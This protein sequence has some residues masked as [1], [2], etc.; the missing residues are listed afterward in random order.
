MLNA[1]NTYKQALFTKMPSLRDNLNACATLDKLIAAETR[2][3]VLVAESPL[4]CVVDGTG[5]CLEHP[6]DK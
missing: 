4:D 2:I 1:W 3:P 6:L 5:I